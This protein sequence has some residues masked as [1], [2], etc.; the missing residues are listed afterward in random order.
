LLSSSTPQRF[1]PFPCLAFALP[2]GITDNQATA[3]RFIFSSV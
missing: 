2:S 3:A 1:L